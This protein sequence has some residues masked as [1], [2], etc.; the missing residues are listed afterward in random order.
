M[1]EELEKIVEDEVLED[2]QDESI[3]EAKK[4]SMGDPSEVPEPTAATAKAP[5]GSTDSAVA[6]HRDWG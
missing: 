3:D 5:P 1:S 6:V 2:A 4:A